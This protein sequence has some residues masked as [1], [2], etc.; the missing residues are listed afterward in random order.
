MLMTAMKQHDGVISGGAVP[1]P[2]PV[3]KKYSDTV[4]RQEETLFRNSRLRTA[5][6]GDR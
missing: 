2:G 1:S 4:V 6:D 3:T 5:I